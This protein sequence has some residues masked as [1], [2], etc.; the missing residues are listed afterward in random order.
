MP[1]LSNVPVDAALCPPVQKQR[2]RRQYAHGHRHHLPRLVRR[3]A[4]PRERNLS[5][6]GACSDP[7]TLKMYPV[8]LR[9]HRSRSPSNDV[10]YSTRSG[11]S[12]L[13]CFSLEYFVVPSCLSSLGLLCQVSLLCCLRDPASPTT[14]LSFDCLFLRVPPTF[15]SGDHVMVLCPYYLPFCFSDSS[16]DRIPF[17]FIAV[18]ADVGGFFAAMDKV[19]SEL[20]R[21]AG[22]GEGC[23]RDG[24]VHCPLLSPRVGTSSQSRT[25]DIG[26][27][28]LIFI[29]RSQNKDSQR[30]INCAETLYPSKSTIYQCRILNFFTS[31]LLLPCNCL[32]SKTTGSILIFLLRYSCFHVIALSLCSKTT[33]KKKQPPNNQVDAGG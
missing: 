32:C 7:F 13:S 14:P 24:R 26:M 6:R 19:L 10:E 8:P 4:R 33:D 3:R 9:S 16:L 17:F 11:L 2:H 20:V 15:K 30:E 5:E 29:Q 27:Q 1:L 21:A 25:V 23:G 18:T 28:Y 22:S 31:I 12:R